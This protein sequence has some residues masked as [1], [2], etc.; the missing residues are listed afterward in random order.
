M[1]Y[2]WSIPSNL[3]IYPAYRIIS[4]N[5]TNIYS[6]LDEN[7]S[8]DNTTADSEDVYIKPNSTSSSTSPSG[9]A[10]D[11]PTSVSIST[12]MLGPA[13]TTMIS[14][15]SPASPNLTG[16]KAG[17][18]VG[19]TVVGLLA[20]LG[21]LLFLKRRQSQKSQHENPHRSGSCEKPELEGKEPQEQLLEVSGDGT[22]ELDGVQDRAERS[23]LEGHSRDRPNANL[24]AN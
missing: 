23:E 12:S 14:T 11:P 16:A 17:I 7:Y 5:E 21:I 4:V 8:P 9:T 2:D 20:I 24:A 6:N 13:P 22:R 18:G 19:C 3:T 15:P 1:S 10:T